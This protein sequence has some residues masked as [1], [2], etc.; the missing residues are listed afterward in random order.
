MFSN[1]KKRSRGKHALVIMEKGGKMMQ[2]VP[3][4]FNAE[5]NLSI[6]SS[7]AFLTTHDQNKTNVMVTAWGSLGYMWKLPVLVA[8]VRKSRYT[9][10]FL[11]K[12]RE[13]TASIPYMDMAR[14]IEICGHQSGRKLD[15]IA[16]CGFNLRHGE[17]IATPVLDIPGMH[18]ECKIIYNRLMSAERLDPAI[19]ELWYDH[20]QGNYHAF[21][22]AQVV[23]SYLLP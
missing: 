13:F 17:K 14:E 16:A 15:K 12:T 23:D 10:S 18:F 6:L 21:F 3:F 5:K 9:Y 11:T 1:Q 22:I 7:A 4:L 2:R 19:N 20:A 8:M